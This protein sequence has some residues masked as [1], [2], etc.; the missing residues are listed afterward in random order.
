MEEQ[1]QAQAA[2]PAAPANPKRRFPTIGDLFAL[3]G[4]TLAVQAV[5]G[6]LLLLAAGLTG[7]GKEEI[8]HDSRFLCLAYLVSMSLALIGALLYR[9]R[10]GGTGKIVSFS[11]ARLHPLLLGWTCVLIFATGIVIE[12]LLNLLPDLTPDF[13]TGI[14]TIVMTL[15][16]AP[17]FEELLCRGVVLGSMRQRYGV[18]AAWLGSAL[19]FGIL[20]LNPVQVVN[21]FILGLILGYIYLVTDSI[22]APILLHAFNNLTAY[23]LMTCCGKMLFIDLVGNRTLY[24]A[25]YIAALAVAAFSAYKIWEAMRRMKQAEKIGADA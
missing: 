15:L 19:F 25:I 7:A 2:V 11:T 16:F 20:H 4:I 8:L 14:W 9:R 21:A 10:R 12:P 23:I 3:L 5:V 6:P 22:W 18:I 17:V 24:G 1:K 13:G